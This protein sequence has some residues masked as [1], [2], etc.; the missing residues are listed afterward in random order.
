MRMVILD[1]V[2]YIVVVLEQAMI[3]VMAIVMVVMVMV[4]IYST[5]LPLSIA[6][7]PLK[8]LA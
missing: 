5:C 4:V 2:I 3:R 8:R 1:M 6:T 7:M